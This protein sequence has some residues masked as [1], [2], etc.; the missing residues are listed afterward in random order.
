M[1]ERP[2][3]KI[4]FEYEGVV[5]IAKLYSDTINEIKQEC[6]DLKIKID[7]KV[8]KLLPSNTKSEDLRTCTRRILDY[9]IR[10]KNKNAKFYNL[11][12]YWTICPEGFKL[13]DYL[14]VT[15]NV[16]LFQ[17]NE[18][19][20]STLESSSSPIK[21]R[22]R[23]KRI[24]KSEIN[25]QSDVDDEDEIKISENTSVELE[26]VAKEQQVDELLSELEWDD[27]LES[28]FNQIIENPNDNMDEKEEDDDEQDE[29]EDIEDAKII[30]KAQFKQLPLDI[31]EHERIQYQYVEEIIYTD[32][33]GRRKV[34]R[35]PRIDLLRPELWTNELF[36]K[37]MK[38]NLVPPLVSSSSSF[39]AP[40]SS[41]PPSSVS[42]KPLPPANKTS[43]PCIRPYQSN[44]LSCVTNIILL[45]GRVKALLEL[46]AL[47]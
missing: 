47:L 37:Y 5:A 13:R 44:N 20:P 4:K 31:N 16:D 8:V 17:K 40:S 34:L 32:C 35:I 26:R 22:S 3:I 43:R 21:K 29:N 45:L 12:K 33:H 19:R 25:N 10:K 2:F 23:K 27:R 1:E 41:S 9:G 42:S 46:S 6:F 7:E 24:L 39:S 38:Y 36:E 14:Y 30:Q 11:I 18:K 28:T 15:Y